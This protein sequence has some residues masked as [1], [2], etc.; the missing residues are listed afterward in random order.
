MCSL[1]TAITIY[2]DAISSRDAAIASATAAA[3]SLGLLDDVDLPVGFR[4]TGADRGLRIN[5][6][7]IAPSA[8]WLKPAERALTDALAMV[9]RAARSM[10]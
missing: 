8:G 5:G 3:C 7:R 4:T 10:R 9:R 1:R 6:N 2:I